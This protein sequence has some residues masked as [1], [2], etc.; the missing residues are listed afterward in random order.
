MKGIEISAAASRDMANIGISLARY[1]TERSDGFFRRMGEVFSLLARSPGLGRLR[2]DLHN[3]RS[4]A[5]KPYVIFYRP[6]EKGIVVVRVI[7]GARDIPAVFESG[8]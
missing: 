2:P 8:D 4:F 5:S 3:V 7:H 1:G 6:T